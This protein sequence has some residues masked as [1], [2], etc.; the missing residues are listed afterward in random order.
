MA[1]GEQSIREQFVEKYDKKF[2]DILSEGQDRD[3]VIKLLW[4]GYTGGY[5]DGYNECFS[6]FTKRK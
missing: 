3:E 2:I 4:V 6:F 1:D 5:S